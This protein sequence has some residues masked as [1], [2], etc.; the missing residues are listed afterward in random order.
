N[1][2]T[3]VLNNTRV[4]RSARDSQG[5]H[6]LIKGI[7]LEPDWRGGGTGRYRLR[8]NLAD[9]RIVDL[10][11]DS[12]SKAVRDDIIAII[13]ND[14]NCAGTDLVGIWRQSQGQSAGLGHTAGRQPEKD[15]RIVG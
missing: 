10:G 9:R 1:D 11:Q 8:R 2:D 7:D 15:V 13:S 12:E 5:R 3:A 4:A 6:R 14:P